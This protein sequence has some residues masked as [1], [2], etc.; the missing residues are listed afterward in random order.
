MAT[1]R[2]DV[3]LGF[4]PDTK[5]LKQEIASLQTQ[6]SKIS[7]G[8]STMHANV[9]MKGIK[10]A[11]AAAQELQTHLERA[12]DFKTG[13]LNIKTFQNS[14]QASGKTLSQYST[15]LL[16]AGE[17]GEEAFLA[18]NQSLLRANMNIKKSNGLLADF[19]TT[20]KN[21]VK[22]QISS[23][24]IHGFMGAI[25]KAT[26]YAQS[27]DESLNSIRIV[28]GY[29]TDQMAKFAK[30]ANKAAQAL[31]TST[32]KYTDASL[33]YYQQG[34]SAKEVEERTAVTIKMANVTGSAVSEVSNQMTS[35]WNNFDDG[36]KSLEYYA[37]VITALG[38][39]TAS[40]TDEITTGLEKFA[41]IGETIGLSYE[42]ATSALATVTATTRQSAEVVGTAFKTIFARIQGLNLGETLDDG[43]TLNQYSEALAKVGV[44]IKTQ[45]GELKNMDTILDEMGA[46]W[47]TI[48]RDQQVALAQTVAGT[49]QYTQLVALMDN[50]SGA[51]QQN[52]QTAA[53]ST[54]SLQKQQDIYTDSWAASSQRV[55]TALQKIYDTLIDEEFFK[56]FNNNLAKAL[57][58]VDVFL[59]SLGGIKGVLLLIS[60]MVINNFQPSLINAFDNIGL[61]IKDVG[62]YLQNLKKQAQG[63]GVGSFAKDFATG[64]AQSAA[65]LALRT[66]GPSSMDKQISESLKAGLTAEIQIS[67]AGRA[68]VTNMQQQLALKK[69]I[70]SVSNKMSDLD[71]NEVNA[72]VK[73]IQNLGEEI[74][75]LTEKN[76]I[77]KNTLS[78]LVE[79][80]GYVNINDNARYQNSVIE[81]DG[82]VF[83]HT[84]NVTTSQRER[85]LSQIGS[86]GIGNHGLSYDQAGDVYTMSNENNE[87][88]Q[89]TSKV[90]EDTK[91]L[92]SVQEELKTSIKEEQEILKKEREIHQELNELGKAETKEKEKQQK[93]LTEQAQQYDKQV[94]QLREQREQLGKTVGLQKDQVH[95]GI[96]LN[97][98]VNNRLNTYRDVLTVIGKEGRLVDETVQTVRE[99]FNLEQKLVALKN[100][101]AQ[102]M[103]NIKNKVNTL[104]SGI[105]SYS[106]VFASSLTSFSSIAFM[107]NSISNVISTWNDDTISW[108]QKLLSVSMMLGSIVSATQTVHKT[109]TLLNAVQA[110]NLLKNKANTSEVQRELLVRL[111][112]LN[113]EKLSTAARAVGLQLEKEESAKIK[114]ILT[115]QIK[116]LKQRQLINLAKAMGI[117]LEEMSDT[118]LKEKLLKKID[119]LSLEEQ[120][121][122]METSELGLEKA[123]TAELKQQ[124][125]LKIAQKSAGGLTKGQATELSGLTDFNNSKAVK[126]TNIKGG[127]Y[128]VVA[129]AAIAITGKALSALKNYYNRASIAAQEAAEMLEKY[130]ERLQE[131]QQ[132]YDDLQTSISNYNTNQTGLKDLTKGTLEYTQQLIAAN[133]AARELIEAGDLLYGEDYEYDEDGLIKF[134]NDAIS[135]AKAAINN[136]LKI[137]QTNQILAA[138]KQ[139]DLALEERK[140]DFLRNNIKSGN[141]IDATASADGMN[142][143]GT[144]ATGIGGGAIAGL[145]AAMSAMAL[146]AAVG[147][148][149]PIAGTIIGAILGG[150]YGLYQIISQ[151]TGTATGEE[152]KALNLL[153][154]NYKERGEIVLEA[155]EMETLLKNNGISQDLIDELKDNDESLRNLIQSIDANT[156]AQIAS[157]KQ[158]VSSVNQNDALYMAHSTEA[159]SIMDS[160]VARRAALEAG[161]SGEF[162]KAYSEIK[163]AYQEDK[164]EAFEMYTS[165]AFSDDY[166]KGNVRVVNQAWR[167]ST[168]QFR[169]EKG[170]YQDYTKENGL[171]LEDVFN[172]YALL[173]SLQVS[174]QDQDTY[175]AIME[176][177][178]VITKAAVVSQEAIQEIMIGLA[179]GRAIDVS[180]IEP[181]QIEKIKT[182][183]EDS[184]KDLTTEYVISIN[185]ALD[186]YS[187]E[188]Y[189]ARMETEAQNVITSGA[190]ELELTEQAVEALTNQILE[191][192]KALG[193][194]KKQ[195]AET[196]VSTLRFSKS[197]NSLKTT[198]AD[199][200]SNIRNFN[201]NSLDC[202]ESLG[203]VEKALEKTFGLKVDS[204]FVV[205]N[206]ELINKAA[207]GSQQALTDLGIELSKDFVKNLQYAEHFIDSINEELEES[208]QIKIGEKIYTS[209]EEFT[210]GFEASKDIVLGY[211]DEIKG[212]NLS[213]G[214]SLIDSLADGKTEE[215]IANLNYLAS[216]TEMTVA[217]MNSLLSEMGIQAKVKQTWVPGSITVPQYTTQETLVS[218]TPYEK[219]WTS[220]TWPS[221]EQLIE[222]GGQ[223]VASI[224]YDGSDPSPQITYVGTKGSLGSSKNSSSS[225]T[226]SSAYT[227][228]EAKQTNVHLES[229]RYEDINTQLD[230]IS[231]NLSKIKRQ[232]DEAFGADKLK[233]ID[234]ETKALE[235]ENEVFDRAI[236]EA[237]AYAEKDLEYAQQLGIA[238]EI[239]A[240]TGEILNKDAISDYIV[241]TNNQF[242]EEETAIKNKY[243]SNNPAN[244]GKSKQELKA[245]QEAELKELKKRENFF[246]QGERGFE[247]YNESMETAYD[248][249]EK[250]EEN[251]AKIREN[252]YERIVDQHEQ[253]QSTI[254]MDNQI[255]EF[256]ISL[257]DDT[258]YTKFGEIAGLKIQ[259]GFNEL[260]SADFLDNKLAELQEKYA[261]TDI[262]AADYQAGLTNIFSEALSKADDLQAVQEYFNTLISDTID[263]IKEDWDK[264]LSKFDE[265]ND[266]LEHMNTI[267]ELTGRSMNLDAKGVI[268]EGQFDV[269][270]DK[271]GATETQFENFKNI[272]DDMVA[273]REELEEKR[274]AGEGVEEELAAAMRDEETAYTNMITA[275]T[276]LRDAWVNA[277]EKAQEILD[278]TYEMIKKEQENTFTNGK[279]FD[280]LKTQMETLQ[281]M[282]EDSLTETNKIYKTNQMIR[283]ATIAL[284]KTTNSLAKE[285]L[286]AF[287]DQTKELQK[288]DKLSSYELEKAQA[289]YS[290]LEAELA[291]EEAKSNKSTVRLQKNA[292]GGY[293]YVYIA[294]ETNISEAEQSLADAQ[295]A[296]YNLNLENTNNYYQKIFVLQEEYVS[297]YNEIVTNELLT[298]SEKL[299]QLTALNQ[300]YYAQ[301]E[302][303]QRV[304]N[305]SATALGNNLSD[306]WSASVEVMKNQ[307]SGFMSAVN[308]EAQALSQSLNGSLA[309]T[310]TNSMRIDLKEFNETGE[311]WLQ[312]V[313]D[314]WEIYGKRIEAIS[315]NDENSVPKRIEKIEKKT[316]D[317]RKA[318]EEL[319]DYLDPGNK[320]GF[321]TKISEAWDSAWSATNSYF[322]NLSGQITSALTGLENIALYIKSIKEG[323]IKIPN[324]KDMDP[325][326]TVIIDVEGFEVELKDS[327]DI[328]EYAPTDNYGRIITSKGAY[329]DV[330][331]TDGGIEQTLGFT[332]TFTDSLVVYNKTENGVFPKMTNGISDILPGGKTYA[333]T[334]WY[335]DNQAGNH[336]AGKATYC[337]VRGADGVTYWVSADRLQKLGLI[338]TLIF[339]KGT[340]GFDT[341]G[342]TGEWGP[343]GKLATLHEKELVL[344][345]DDTKNI[346]EAVE[347][348]RKTSG[349]IMPTEREQLEYLKANAA[350][351]STSMAKELA[352]QGILT[353]ND[354]I[355]TIVNKLESNI[356]AQERLSQY[357]LSAANELPSFEGLNQNLDQNVHITAEFPNVQDHNEI[358]LALSD[359]VNSASQYAFKN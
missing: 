290:I 221:G 204:D 135:K 333:I 287:I 184:A 353:S 43:T 183:L 5:A 155:E 148:A 29:G 177:G 16:K 245:A 193:I 312:Q 201:K 109:M 288:Q 222:G 226:S 149:V 40:S 322:K 249:A 1:N 127:L 304:Y 169:D 306:S 34:L 92:V 301:A 335:I 297:R 132:R 345:K 129:A 341:G 9:D 96:T 308:A 59:N 72:E 318:S 217:D 273:R 280:W 240:E 294:D 102:L 216:A 13:E 24:L 160:I 11:S 277:A 213:I 79:E 136:E 269:L 311:T 166:K 246:E 256:K 354:L 259:T 105:A 321:V 238:L 107:A 121:N 224:S 338:H 45:S 158:M 115:D 120:L 62:F 305:I 156:Q 42:Y 76:E 266:K 65:E 323:S 349:T 214:D 258:D 196:A 111:Q 81:D 270:A 122:L 35:V 110:V 93:I 261:N 99:Q 355:R 299:Q 55:Q 113:L 220:V 139:K 74:V 209:L 68:Q 89:I 4:Q 334:D 317:V 271:V 167:N 309:M 279:G 285:K 157:Y 87:R 292:E 179:E 67:E 66:E 83:Y 36:T 293:G 26:G 263:S 53:N 352:Q 153:I 145:A 104:K 198:V 126:S 181:E 339:D 236:E 171:L 314:A 14:L 165:L 98:T 25:Q 359:L 264:Q 250:K 237:T 232:K 154:D 23:S 134:S 228:E 251:L 33:I 241:E 319:A 206:I 118:N 46:K 252:N 124:L 82:R 170:V 116:S 188:K 131:T 112:A 182:A 71:L 195:A 180:L 32:T 125:A 230:K 211:I 331:S 49:R 356:F 281:S 94:G 137:N 86:Y 332:S 57:Q 44:S 298:E 108:T 257:I 274:D 31:S 191:E 185:A 302:E 15:Q 146:G 286:Q 307:T 138:Q 77:A 327:Y 328:G 272:Y 90:L 54:G 203:L 187:V 18:L 199:N 161:E 202:W 174:E 106:A 278:N 275:Q 56:D 117:E 283:T 313:G 239:D 210:A 164:N 151:G 296:L 316:D 61:K 233:L 75:L 7:T 38:A 348:M 144:V 21:T 208:S 119:E 207:N 337:Q 347:L 70:Y 194:N 218:Q 41:A 47:N 101:Q 244:K 58:G 190:A 159:Q 51:M 330:S 69:E 248:Y 141:L 37:D 235:A 215:F 243:N 303:L 152:Q 358:E 189:Y 197:L 84:Q 205:E 300:D 175:N 282:Q 320:D 340:Y 242:A 260:D 6:L 227:S 326:D 140:V 48:S 114:E 324:V 247:R 91:K 176:V 276:E 123:K 289:E 284:E 163:K 142:N 27:L 255:L 130:N 143:I 162:A 350:I 351:V 342:Y 234:N 344:N 147:S 17:T 95:N 103:D 78:T 262:S 19:A 346:L 63:S 173:K 8:M 268:L 50:W 267:L 100:K 219:T 178:S 325:G 336:G 253:L 310:I 172:D 225:S 60:S 80:A 357:A 223:Y 12:T 73:Q 186:K 88:A 28:T 20:L 64:K 133:E 168:L 10:E 231:R 85:A 254:D 212:A 39:A 30:E 128:M 97:N 200:I 2:L 229:D 52:L 22:W 329:A 150:G 265:L 315:G 295:N 343:E 192:N 3:I 291:L